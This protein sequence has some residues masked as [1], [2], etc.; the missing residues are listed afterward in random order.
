MKQT[1][2]EIFLDRLDPTWRGDQLAFFRTVAGM[3]IEAVDELADRVSRVSCPV[4]LRQLTLEFSY[5]F[6]WSEWVPAVDRVLR[7]EKDL[8]L[9]ETGV[10][11]LGRM[12]TP[13][14]LE[15]LRALS[16]SRAT[17]GFQ[18]I[19]NQVLQECD[20][21]GAFNHHFT[22]L[23]Q[24]SAQPADANEGAHQLAKLICADSFGPLKTAV[25]H[26]DP[27][28]FRHALRLMGTVPSAEAAEFLLVY[29]K[30]TH[31]DSLQDREVRSLL[32]EFRV[33]PHLE[34][35]A[36]ALQA[37]TPRLEARPDP[38][39]AEIA[40]LASE[41]P[42]A[43]LAAASQ[44]K[45]M[46]PGLL[47][48][49]LLETLADALVDKPAH[50]AKSLGQASEVAQRRTRRIEFALDSAAQS[51]A[52]M[53]EEGLIEPA[54]V[55]ETL[56]E[57]LRLGTGYVGMASALARLVRPEEEELTD[58]MLGQADGAIRGAALEVLGGRFDAGFRPAF[59]KLR[60]D[61][62]TDIADRSLWHLGKLPG[63]VETARD[64]LAN[65]DPE[66][67]LVG[68][69]FI[70]MHQLE[71]LV[72]D[73]IE[74]VA[75]ETRESLLITAL[76]TL[77]AIGSPQAVEP[78]L[79]LMHSG[80]GPRILL[81]LAE[82]LRDLGT[83]EGA[84]ALCGKAEE[85]NNP[86]LRTV[87]VEALAKA[88]GTEEDPLP[89]NRSYVL[90]KAVRGGWNDRQPWPLR[91]RIAD[92]LVGIRPENSGIWIELSGLFQT[93][94]EEKRPPGAVATE[95]LTRVQACARVLAQLAAL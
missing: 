38:P 33:L 67:V 81:A 93:T 45:G 82:S 29:L 36:K 74:R 40:G 87:A 10:R 58:L 57:S 44:L 52:T 24:G 6:P 92:A 84:L 37:L 25:G 14:A 3:G 79:A 28:V 43:I 51:L 76:H 83:P 50:L 19:V 21:A 88:H 72:P 49:F 8:R 17:P 95:D 78:L 85:L 15:C 94:L 13:H 75:Q 70:A 63:P 39:L 55:M 56:A 65:P 12:E 35:K 7:H 66:E 90:I 69:R 61:A 30:E 54:P 11:A 4:G 47:D 91:R 9:F 77:G 41:D 2:F 1:P 23:L 42:V 64:F 32:T 89:A 53:A 27:L 86:L 18:E 73:L 31:L 20:P 5:Y 48:G 62:I 22:R 71:E 34:V 80:Q 26:P 60:R 68:L 46:E 16:L 59:M